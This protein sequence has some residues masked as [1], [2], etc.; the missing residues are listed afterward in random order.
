MTKCS[1]CYSYKNLIKHEQI[2]KPPPMHGSVCWRSGAKLRNFKLQ[3]S[4]IWLTTD[5][6]NTLNNH[7]EKF[8]WKNRALPITPEIPKPSQS[9]YQATLSCLTWQI[10]RDIVPPRWYDHTDAFKSCIT[11]TGSH[12]LSSIHQNKQKQKNTSFNYLTIWLC[13][14]LTY[15]NCYE[16]N[17]TFVPAKNLRTLLERSIMKWSNEIFSALKFPINS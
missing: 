10:R 4:K 2:V 8:R 6:C 17:K 9:K 13:R 14:Y 7:V 11:P 12:L 1:Q 16:E 3:Q 15:L 5:V